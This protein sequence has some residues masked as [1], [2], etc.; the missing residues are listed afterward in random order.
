MSLEARIE[1]YFAAGAACVG[2]Q[3]ALA[4]FQ[5]L[6]AGLEAGYR[7]TRVDPAGHRVVFRR[8]PPRENERVPGRGAGV[9]ARL[10]AELGGTVR[11][12]P[13]VDLTEPTGEVWDAEIQ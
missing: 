8:E 7:T 11:I 4:A 1:Q 5:E 6:R 10:R 9:V 13:G 12:A 2:D 3:D